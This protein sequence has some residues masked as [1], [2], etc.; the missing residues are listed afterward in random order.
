MQENSQLVQWAFVVFT[1]DT[2]QAQQGLQGP[3]E[4]TPNGSFETLLLDFRCV[5]PAAQYM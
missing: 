1:D 3:Q 2:S 4:R 5:G